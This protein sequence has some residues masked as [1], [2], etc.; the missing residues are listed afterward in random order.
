MH[1]LYISINLNMIHFPVQR[2][3]DIKNRPKIPVPDEDPYSVAENAGS[4]GSGSSG[5][6]PSSLGGYVTQ[7]REQQKMNGRKGDNPPK[8]PPRDN[9]YPYNTKVM[10]K[11][12]VKKL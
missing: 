1:L 2:P 7:T 3:V 11:V 12:L 6:G 5:F 4:S 8:L 9:G 10:Q